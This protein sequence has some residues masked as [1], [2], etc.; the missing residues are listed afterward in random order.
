MKNYGIATIHEFLGDRVVYRNLAPLD[1]TL[2]GLDDL[3]Q[4]TGLPPGAIPRKSDPE[5]ARV[6]VHMLAAAR[7]QDAPGVPIQRL[8]F[9]GDTRLLDGTAFANLCAAGGWPG[10]AFIGSETQ[11]EPA[12]EIIPAGEAQALYL[13][14]RWAALPA[15]D[16]YCQAQGLLVD[17]HAAV[18]VDLD[19][20]ALGARGRNAGVIDQARLQAV[21][22][23]LAGLLGAAFDM[24]LFRAAYEPLNQ[25]EFHPFTGDNQDYLAYICLILGA[26]LYSRDT[27]I[28]QV[29][30][31][32]LAS[33]TQFIESVEADKKKLPRAVVEIHAEI[34]ANVQR[35][36]P[37]PFKTFRRNEYLSTIR[38]F[39]CAED[40]APV[41][42]LLAEEI[43]ITQEVRHIALAWRER[44]ALLFGLSD[45]P[46]EA[47]LPTSE[48]AAQGY[49][50]LHR[51]RTHAVGAAIGAAIGE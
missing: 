27:L 48:L 9:V 16:R 17:Q 45:K 36:D 34:Y 14:N 1:P 44:G 33:F 49:L 30:A 29:R 12:V 26:G 18:I 41:D 43:A 31:G 50:P 13:S 19:K 38:L 2:P 5:Y 11:A 3:R 46:D 8:I 42:K 4:A 15:F 47:A 51:A 25:P 20:T 21:Q 40:T 28:A 39:G 35:G 10:I 22:D 24:E 37:T 7:R 32:Q 6:V 23:T